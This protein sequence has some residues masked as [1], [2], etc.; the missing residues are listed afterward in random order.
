MRA[1]LRLLVVQFAIGSLVVRISTKPDYPFELQLPRCTNS[2]F[3]WMIQSCDTKIGNIVHLFFRY[4]GNQGTGGERYHLVFAFQ[5]FQW[6]D[7]YL[8]VKK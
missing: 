6:K 2:M 5:M 7:I 1:D 8:L 3:Q 4:Q